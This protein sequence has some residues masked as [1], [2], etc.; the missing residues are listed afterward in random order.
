MLLRQARSHALLSQSELGERAGVARSVIADYERGRN[1]PTVRQLD[2]LLAA[3]GLLVAV[4]L[5]PLSAD[6]DTAIRRC[7]ARPVADRLFELPFHLGALLRILAGV[8]YRIEGAAAALLQGAPVPVPAVDVAIADT[9][10]VLNTL[11]RRIG[12]AGY[13]WFWVAEDH[14]W[15]MI[16]PTA[17]LLRERGPVTRWRVVVGEARL[18]LVHPTEISTGICVEVDG[19]RVPV[20]GLWQLEATD[21]QSRAIL[22]RSRQLLGEAAAGGSH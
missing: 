18:R 15:Q 7:L 12:E 10:P 3:A 11:A 8:P 6:L 2:R 13:I 20:L 21:E 19:E 5:K 17:A 22:A 1:S 14:R 4:Q 9:D 16:K